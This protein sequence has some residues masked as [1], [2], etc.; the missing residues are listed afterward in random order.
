MPILSP[1]QEG[2]L[3]AWEP[4]F[5]KRKVL[6][7]ASGKLAGK[8][9]LAVAIGARPSVYFSSTESK[10]IVVIH[11]A[12]PDLKA[13]KGERQ[14]SYDCRKGLLALVA[15]PTDASIL[16]QLHD[17]ATISAVSMRTG[18]RNPELLWS[19]PLRAGTLIAREVSPPAYILACCPCPV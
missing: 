10:E 8:L 19:V 13:S 17:D 16:F 2:A 4:Q 18:Q 9:L 7:P 5:W 1:S 11:T 3:I 15:H 6:L 12:V 14:A